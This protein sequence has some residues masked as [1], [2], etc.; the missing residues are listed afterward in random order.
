MQ[1]KKIEKLQTEGWTRLK[2]NISWGN[3]QN[4]DVFFAVPSEFSD[5]IDINSADPF[6]MAFIQIAAKYNENIE[7]WDAGVSNELAHNI[8]EKLIPVLAQMG[9]GNGN[10]KVLASEYRIPIDSKKIAA[11]GISLGIDSFYSIVTNL[12]AEN[13]ALPINAV[14]YIYQVDA[15]ENFDISDLH[16]LLKNQRK[17]ADG[18]KLK[19]IPIVTNV[20]CV[21]ETELIFSQF[22]TFS[23]MGSVA[24]LRKLIGNYYYATG[25]S[26]DEM[27]LRFSD[28]GSYENIIQDV[29]SFDGFKML[30]AG[31]EVTRFEKTKVLSTNTVVR[32][33][34]DV[35]YHDKENKT[36]YLNCSSCAK[37]IRTMT[38]LDVI[39]KLEDF[40]NVF[41]TELYNKSK[42]KYWA[43]VKYRKIIGKNPLSIEICDA[44]KKAGYH[45]PIMHWFYFIKIGIRNQIAKIFRK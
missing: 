14:V 33:Y 40:G 25:Y 36:K 19:L 38:T 9:C 16:K 35:C 24:A 5:S 37:C 31:A 4:Y 28:S 23:D 21:M 27:A 34:L 30:S 22:H 15:W 45:I 18:Y 13:E 7:V 44:A 39:G 43:D 1:I 10:T 20:R 12:P 11:T 3:N 29:F 6:V 41:D 17:V 8:E 26:Y 42:S 32:S 2:A